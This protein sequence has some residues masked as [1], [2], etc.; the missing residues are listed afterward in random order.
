MKTRKR[1]WLNHTQSIIL[2]GVLT[3]GMLAILCVPQ[4]TETTHAQSFS[5]HSNVHNGVSSLA[6]RQIRA[7]EQKL[8]NAYD[9][10]IAANILADDEKIP[11]RINEETDTAEKE[12]KRGN[13]KN[14]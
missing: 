12:M 1:T 2:T 14:K 11:A 13:E 10:N 7:D 5:N 9:L 4:M 8:D 3:L 6:E